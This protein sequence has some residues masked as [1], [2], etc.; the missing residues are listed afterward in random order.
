MK[1]R[2]LF[3]AAAL[4][5]MVPTMA[6]ATSIEIFAVIACFTFSDPAENYCKSIDRKT[7]YSIDRCEEDRQRLLHPGGN[8]VMAPH[9]KLVCMKKSVSTWEPVERNQEGTLKR[10]KPVETEDEQRASQP[11]SPSGQY[12]LS[13]ETN[14]FLESL[15]K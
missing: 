13:K 14:E 4:A 8:I 15:K 10:T 2:F 11:T 6:N 7:F 12:E 5:L 9:V 3:Y 1:R